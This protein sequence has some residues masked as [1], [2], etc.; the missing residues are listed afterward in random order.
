MVK[1]G[2]VRSECCV[3]IVYHVP[4]CL[5]FWLV[6]SHPQSINPSREKL[7]PPW[8]DSWMSYGIPKE[9]LEARVNLFKPYHSGRGLGGHSDEILRGRVAFHTPALAAGDH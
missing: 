6:S 4:F 8:D 5:L 1:S 9:Q 2:N 7:Q 3:A